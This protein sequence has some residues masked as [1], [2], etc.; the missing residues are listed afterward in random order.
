MMKV[1]NSLKACMAA[2]MVTAI[3]VASARAQSLDKVTL[4]LNWYATGLHAP[5]LLG[6]QKGYF[7]KEGLD[8]EVQ[9]GKG[10]GPTVQAVAAENVTIGFADITTMMKLVSKGAPV[11]SVGSALERSPFAVISLSEKKILQPSDIKGKTIAMT[12]GDSP[13]QAWPLFLEKNGLKDTD[14]KTVTGDAKTKINAVINGQADA[15]LGFATDQGNQIEFVTKKPVSLML[16]ADH[17]V[18]SVGSSFI[19][20]TA[21]LKEH[22]EMIRRFMRAAT[23]AFEDA[24]K[25]PEAAVD[26]L[27]V[28][29][30]KAG[31]KESL[32]SGLKTA[33]PLFHT[34]DTVGQKPLRVSSQAMEKTIQTM[35]DTGGIDKSDMNASK[36]FTNEFLP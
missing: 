9:E 28:A 20:N 21:T 4:M 2:V 5:I 25:E 34:Q 3:V 15:L 22:P 27:L 19:V 11:I 17:G 14:Y 12:A 8:L 1:G 24:V 26:A 35:V 6:K 16:F 32:M 29:F 23:L 7:E 30:P 13:S 33:I 36:F 31:A 18:D 10:S